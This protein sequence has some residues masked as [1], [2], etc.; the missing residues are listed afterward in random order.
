MQSRHSQDLSTVVRE[1][2]REEEQGL[3]TKGIGRHLSLA[4]LL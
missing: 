3:L 1:K 4:L 2:A